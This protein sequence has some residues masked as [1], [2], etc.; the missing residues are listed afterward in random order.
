MTRIDE[1]RLAEIE[2]GIE[3]DEF[4]QQD[5]ADLC[6]ELRTARVALETVAKETSDDDTWAHV[7]RVLAGEGTSGLSYR[8]GGGDE[9]G[10]GGVEMT[11]IELDDGKYTVVNEL[12]DGGGFY[13][14]RYGEK[15]R[16]LVGD[17]LVYAMFSEIERLR[18]GNEEL[19][20]VIRILQGRGFD[21]DQN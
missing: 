7:N 1:K 2:E 18:D 16:N 4:S 21:D 20:E 6:A 8:M 17:K 14:L 5:V 3:Y 12:F 19:R 15:W 10:M 13:A 9:N 11:K